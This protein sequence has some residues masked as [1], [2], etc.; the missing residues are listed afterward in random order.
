MAYAR[1]LFVFVAQR[2]AGIKHS[3][4]AEFLNRD[5]SSITYMIRKIEGIMDV[6]RDPVVSDHLDKIT[7][8]IKV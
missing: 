4:I 8:V 5:A 7:Q 1:A 6:D 3:V 2:Y